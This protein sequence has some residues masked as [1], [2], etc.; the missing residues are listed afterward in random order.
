MGSAFSPEE[1]STYRGVIPQA[2]EAIFDRISE[3][4]GSEFTVRV[5]FVEIHKEEIRDLLA[6][7]Q[8]SNVLIRELPAGGIVLA[9]TVEKEVR[10]QQEMIRVLEEGTSLRAT[11]A[12]GM[13]KHSSRS[14]AIFTITIEQR[15]TRGDRPD[16]PESA[17]EKSDEDED[18][19]DDLGLDDYLCAKMHLVDLAG[20]ERI[21]RTKA[22][23]QRLQEGININKGLLALGNVINALSEG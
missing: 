12:T 23:G 13:N 7:R 17:M 16:T 19:E 2:M 8:T 3:M 14:H 10:T 6:K 20:S 1:N 9:G 22:Q 11:A 4:P 21:K 5:G 15:K 18:E